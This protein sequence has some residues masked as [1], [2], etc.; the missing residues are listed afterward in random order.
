VPDHGFI[1]SQKAA[2]MHK[3]CC[4]AYGDPAEVITPESLFETYGVSVAV[5]FHSQA[6]RQICVPLV[7]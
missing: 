3:G 1:S 6:N 2:I 7:T 4:T 5:E